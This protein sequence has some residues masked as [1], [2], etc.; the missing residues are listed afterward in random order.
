MKSARAFFD[1]KDWQS[2]VFFFGGI[3]F[4][5]LFI[6]IAGQFI[7][8]IPFVGWIIGCFL[9]LAVTIGS[10]AFWLYFEGYK[11]DV[12]EAVSRGKSMDTISYNSEYQKRIING[13]KISLA[14]FIY[15]LP[16]LLLIIISIAPLLIASFTFGFN[17]SNCV[18][19]EIGCVQE[20]DPGSVILG[21][22]STVFFYVVIIVAVLYQFIFRYTVQPGMLVMFNRHRTF[23][24]MFRF[25]EIL[26][27][28]K[29]NASNLL[30]YLAISLLVGFIMGMAQL[31]G[32]FTLFI[33]IG[34]I[35]LPIILAIQIV[36]TQH[37]DSAVI[38][39]MD[40]IDKAAGDS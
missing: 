37:L 14:N 15:F 12:I 1:L 8:I 25:G 24:A 6:S 13:F 28:A 39:E 7:F 34:I 31:V 30:L 16:M 40:R 23:S 33:C 5:I 17:E 19:T 11:L 9:A 20:T 22:T 32:V 36:Y 29:R 10:I 21:L 3:Y 26:R 4:L 2:R 35:L 27:F 38:G 18:S